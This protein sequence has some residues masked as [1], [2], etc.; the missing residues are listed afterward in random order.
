MPFIRL[1]ATVLGLWSALSIAL[2]IAYSVGR[3]A[4]ARQ[5]GAAVRPPQRGA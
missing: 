3:W 5:A 4:A 1:L 2:G